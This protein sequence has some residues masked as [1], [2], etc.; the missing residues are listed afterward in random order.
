MNFMP[1]R[2]WGVARAPL[3]APSDHPFV[4]FGR[5]GVLLLNLG[6]P[7]GTSYWPM[8]RYLKEF[9]TDRRVIEINPVVWWLISIRS[10]LRSGPSPRVRPINRSGTPTATSR[11]CARLHAANAKKW[12]LFSR[13]SLGSRSTGRCDTATPASGP[14]LKRFTTRGAIAFFFFRST[15][16]IQRQRSRRPATRLS[17]R[18]NRC[19][20][21]RLFG[22]F[23][24]TSRI[25]DTS[26]LSPF[27][28][29]QS[30]PNS[31]SSRKW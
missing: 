26:T 20:G 8:R 7:D 23:R 22:S 25:R 9:L 16:N 2:F 21:S 24:L 13:G 12:A 27:P 19:G 10:F 11:R 30:W 1:Q 31:T 29:E 6:T 28:P 3:A 5:I 18:S 4:N 14:G 17:T 15:L